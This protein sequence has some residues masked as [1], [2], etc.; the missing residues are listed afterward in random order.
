MGQ[1]SG[2]ATGVSAEFE[3]RSGNNLTVFAEV[4]K[5]L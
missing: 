2:W 5:Q 3:G 4:M 1:D